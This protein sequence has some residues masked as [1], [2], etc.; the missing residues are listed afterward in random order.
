VLVFLS[1]PAILPVAKPKQGI[2]YATY[3]SVV[4][5]PR[6]IAM[7]ATKIT[8]ALLLL[9]NSVP[10]ASQSSSIAYQRVH[11][12]HILAHVV[13]VNLQDPDVKVTVALA[14][15]GAGKDESF[16]SIVTRTRPNVAITGT[17]FDTKSLKPT[18]DI[19]LFGTVVHSGVIGSALT[20]DQNNNAQITPLAV[21]RRTK[22]QGYET[23]LCAGPTLVADGRI[24]IALAHEGFRR[25]LLAPTRRTAVGITNQGKLVLVCVN[26]RA[27]LY[28]L[29]KLL[30]QLSVQDAV[31]LD[32]GSSTAL[33]YEGKYLAVPGRTL[34]NC[35]VVYASTQAYTAAKA[36]LA[37]RE[38]LAKAETR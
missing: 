37:P 4:C 29:A 5:G 1:K 9:V 3:T 2:L 21:G 25:S 34:T 13:T 27:T 26:R 11:Y 19:A 20:V 6:R 32:G 23:V 33:Y 18:G 15:G 10:Q 36:Y 12:R 38:L 22:W 14:A 35:L 7:I 24:A 17:F 30:I 28:D 31:L 8:S 16:K